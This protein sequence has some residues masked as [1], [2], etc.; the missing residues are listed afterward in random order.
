MFGTGQSGLVENSLHPV[1]VPE[2]AGRFD[3]YSLDAQCLSHLRHWNLQLLQRS[4]QTVDRP[5]P[6]TNRPDRR[7]QLGR[8]EGIGHQVMSGDPIPDPIRELL[9]RLMAHEPQPHARQGEGGGQEACCGWEK[10]GG[11][12]DHTRHQPNASA[13]VSQEAR[14][15]THRPSRRALAT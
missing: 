10:I 2:V 15:S 6:G 7:Y 14:T 11:D 13:G 9:S 5:D 4:H 3:V 1:L 8:V 12:E